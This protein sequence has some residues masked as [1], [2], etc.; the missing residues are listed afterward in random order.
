M[1]IN[2]L[3]LYYLTLIIFKFFNSSSTNIL[4]IL[5]LFKF[6]SSSK[7]NF[8]NMSIFS[9]GLQLKSNHCKLVSSYNTPI[10]FI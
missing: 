2:P 5:V 8:S 4:P 9:I 3:L 1:P 7:I 6:N 10:S